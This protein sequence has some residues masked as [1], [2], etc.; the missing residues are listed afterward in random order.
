MS[1]EGK[2]VTKAPSSLSLVASARIDPTRKLGKAGLELWS[3]IME[4]YVI[5]DPAGIELLMLA[6]GAADR[7]AELN[8]AISKEGVTVRTK[9]GPKAH[10]ALRDELQ[11]RAFISK[12][13]ERLGLNLEAI[14]PTGHKG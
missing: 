6:C 3:A 2:H 9:T 4:A 14:R 10:P 12:Q 1:R 13:L 11:N 7:V 8:A 5:D